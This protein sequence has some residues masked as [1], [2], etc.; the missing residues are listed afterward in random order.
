[1]HFLCVDFFFF[2]SRDQHPKEGTREREKQQH[3]SLKTF[4]VV[5]LCAL[6]NARLQVSSSD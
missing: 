4:V 1:M 2:A 3:L 6:K 5:A